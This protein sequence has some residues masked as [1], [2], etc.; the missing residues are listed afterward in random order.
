MVFALLHKPNHSVIS[1]SVVSLCVV[2]AMVSLG[3]SWSLEPRVAKSSS[4]ES[5]V[6]RYVIFDLNFCEK[7]VK[8]K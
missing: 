6:D 3:S 5:F 7:F 8:L 2:L 1:L 4:L